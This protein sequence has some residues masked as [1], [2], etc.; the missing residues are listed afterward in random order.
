MAGMNN[1]DILSF[2]LR[3]LNETGVELAA[4]ATETGLGLSWLYQ[5]RRGQ[6]PD[7]GVVKIQALADY[8]RR[9]APE[10]EAA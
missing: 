5:L 3:R 4:V 2:V 7:P 1:E 6:I 9:T 10:R 8:F